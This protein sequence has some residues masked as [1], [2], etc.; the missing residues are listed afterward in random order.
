M[1]FEFALKSAQTL[2]DK[3]ELEDAEDKFCKLLNDLSVEEKKGNL[4]GKMKSS[5]MIE[6]ECLIGVAECRSK[7]FKMGRYLKDDFWF[8][9]FIMPLCL[10]HRSRKLLQSIVDA[11]ADP[12]SPDFCR[13]DKLNG[14]FQTKVQNRLNRLE[15]NI[16]SLEDNF[17]RGLLRKTFNG[18]NSGTQ[19]LKPGSSMSVN[20]A[21]IFEL[22]MICDVANV[23]GWSKRKKSD[24]QHSPADADE[25]EDVPN[26]N[27]L[28]DSNIPAERKGEKQPRL[29]SS[30][31]FKHQR[32]SLSTR[33]YCSS[34]FKSGR[35]TESRDIS[36]NPASF[37]SRS[38]TINFERFQEAIQTFVSDISSE[39]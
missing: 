27:K 23:D 35:S 37:S 4:D 34:A 25:S 36:P 18:N 17:I 12:Q 31:S 1:D 15:F 29:K 6:V 28:I 14:D 9:C 16:S 3:L 26:N 20:K 11:N 39:V 32:P 13:S 33:N 19:R 22:V 24:L 5:S 38:R 8:Q 21:W 30:Q 10:L 7:S 2:L